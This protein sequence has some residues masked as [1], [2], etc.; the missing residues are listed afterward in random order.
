MK[1][2]EGRVKGDTEEEETMKGEKEIT[3]AVAHREDVPAALLTHFRC[4]AHTC[5][6]GMK[7]RVILKQVDDGVNERITSSRHAKIEQHTSAKCVSALW[8]RF[9]CCMGD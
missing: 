4:H 5:A 6:Y 8:T 3:V 7:D 1:G 2:T 9:C